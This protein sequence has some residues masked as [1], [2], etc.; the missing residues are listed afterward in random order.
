MDTYLPTFTG[1]SRKPDTTAANNE[2]AGKA[3]SF[4]R[5]GPSDIRL[6]PQAPYGRTGV[7]SVQWL[8]PR[9]PS[10]ALIRQAGQAGGQSRSGQLADM[11][12][13]RANNELTPTPSSAS[14][15]TARNW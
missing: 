4:L 3:D 9:L 11:G 7:M 1:T 5:I 14:A 15:T 12:R 2:L 13:P 10:Y 8:V 6:Q